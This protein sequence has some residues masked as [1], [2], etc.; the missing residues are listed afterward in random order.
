VDFCAWLKFSIGLGYN[1]R[2]GGV[3]GVNDQQ[4]SKINREQQY[5]F[6]LFGVKLL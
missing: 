1:H 3:F 6:F 4:F 5:F 2:G